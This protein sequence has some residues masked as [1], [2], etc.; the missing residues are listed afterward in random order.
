MAGL[1]R[2]LVP[3]LTAM[4]FLRVLSERVNSED[5]L[6]ELQVKLYLFWRIH[7]GSMFFDFVILIRE[8]RHWRHWEV[9]ILKK[10]QPREQTVKPCSFGNSRSK[11]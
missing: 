6:K 11:N 8:V 1:W 4:L 10:N 7:I 2:L 3:A 9:F 5:N